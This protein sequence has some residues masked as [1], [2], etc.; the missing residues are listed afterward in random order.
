MKS[1]NI[2]TVESIFFKSF[3]IP[4]NKFNEACFE[5]YKYDNSISQIST[6]ATITLSGMF[7]DKNETD[8]RMSLRLKESPFSSFN[9]YRRPVI[10]L[11]DVIGLAEDS[12]ECGMHVLSK[13]GDNY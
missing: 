12:F 2:D 4:E 9:E 10:F 7:Y 6:C 8:V 5:N 1:K 11:D 3:N 13:R